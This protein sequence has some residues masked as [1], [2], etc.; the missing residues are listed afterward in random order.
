[1][2]TQISKH[3]RGANRAVAAYKLMEMTGHT[4]LVAITE[5]LETTVSRYPTND[6]TTILIPVEHVMDGLIAAGKL[7][8]CE[9]E[10]RY[11]II[12]PTARYHHPVH[13][14]VRYDAHGLYFSRAAFADN[15]PLT[16]DFFTPRHYA[17]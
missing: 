9:G 7:K 12:V 5:I 6:G 11:T 15:T 4:S 14:D 16:G 10:N 1:M 8:R 3:T 13:F 17:D 2:T